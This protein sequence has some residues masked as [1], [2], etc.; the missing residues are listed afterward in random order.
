MINI[1]EAH[2]DIYIYI[3]IDIWENL[4]YSNSW[5]FRI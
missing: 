5:K 3:Q 1:G 2:K 4:E